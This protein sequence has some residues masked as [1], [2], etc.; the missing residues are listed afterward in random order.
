MEQA[1]TAPAAELLE[2]IERVRRLGNRYSRLLQAELD[3]TVYHV[4]V[5]AAIDDGA[6][7]LHQVADATG[8]QVSGAS[9]LVEKLVVDGLVERRQ[10]ESNRRAVVLELTTAGQRRLAE[11]RQLIARQ[12]NEALAHMPAD[13]AQALVPVL[14]AFLDGADAAA[15]KS[16]GDD[17]IRTGE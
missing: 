7:H 14:E 17:R 13:K 16:G 1:T 9:R 10:D 11:A 12:V 4:G 8:Q 2:A 5:L 6:R 15:E 3:L